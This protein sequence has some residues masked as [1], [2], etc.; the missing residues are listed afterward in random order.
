MITVSNYTDKESSINWND[1]PKA[2]RDSRSD[3]EDMLDL[4]GED[5]TIDN[6]IDSF[7]ANINSKK[8]AIAT[9]HN[10]KKVVKKNKP[11]TIQDKKPASKKKAATKKVKEVVDYKIVDNF[12][13]EF[14]LLRRFLNAT[15]KE[16]LTYQ[17]VRLLYMAF[18]KAAVSRNVRKSSDK[19]DEFELANEGITKM[20][21]QS[22][23]EEAKKHGIK[24][25]IEDTKLI[26]DLTAYVAG[27]KI[28]YA[29]TLLRSF[30]SLQGTIPGKEKAERL[31]KR[32]RNAFK[33]ERL[34][35]KNRLYD[36]VMDAIYEL[37]E[38]LKSPKEPVDVEA[39]GLSVP[40]GTCN[41]RIKCEGL[42]KNGQLLHG[43]KFSKGGAVVK[44]NKKAKKKGLR[45]VD[46][47]LAN[48]EFIDFPG[49][50]I[51]VDNSG[52][53]IMVF[54]D[55]DKEDKAPINL[56]ILK[57]R[58]QFEWSKNNV[59]WNRSQKGFSSKDKLDL[60]VFLKAKAPVKKKSKPEKLEQSI[61]VKKLEQKPKPV[62]KAMPKTVKKPK[63]GLKSPVII[64]GGNSIPLASIETILPI[65]PRVKNLGDAMHETRENEIFN[66]PGDIGEFLGQV[67]KKPVHSVVTTIDA[68]QGAGKTR[69]IFQIMN[70]LAGIGLKC[71]FYSLE[72][73]P[74]SKLFKDKVL[75]YIDPS[76]LTNISVIDEVSIWKDEI[77]VIKRSDAVFF[78]SFQKLPDIDLDKNIRKAFNGK[79]FYIIYQQTGTKTM[80]GGS[81]AAFDGDQI[82]KIKKHENYQD[83]YVF[84]NKNRYQEDPELKFNI[85]TGALVR[86]P[87]NATETTQPSDSR[88]PPNYTGGRLIATPIF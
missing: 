31:L 2:I 66:I 72:E 20:F 10:G 60:L 74:Q 17:Q 12:S 78:D 19:A 87:G 63:K 84:A 28:N 69:F 85:Y 48:D 8:T 86:G 27:T 79:L 37:D 45:I 67:E 21:D 49:G 68:E 53:Q 29:I 24:L 35:D 65:D 71:L 14:K 61:Q 32:F 57:K 64:A 51:I 42:N 16:T 34:N 11:K 88:I 56:T 77:P 36:Q 50:E 59:S 62:K 41:N 46:P 5:K 18:N 47:A 26:E 3:V 30:I 73:H 43:Y 38:Y 70:A 76:N 9:A 83:N 33:T 52:K 6:M 25:K 39:F 7:L 15:K 13:E 4:Y 23:N 22:D 44:V 58:F 55:G 81:K 1:Y 40:R 80:R 82:L 75:K 54:F